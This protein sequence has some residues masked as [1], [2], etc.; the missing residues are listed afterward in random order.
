MMQVPGVGAFVRVLLPVALVGGVTLT[1]GVWLGVDPSNLQYIVREW[2]ASTYP[3][4]VLDGR[5]ASDVKPWGLLAKPGRAVVRDP[6]QT[7]YLDSSTDDQLQT[8]LEP[9][10]ASRRRDGCA[11]RG[12]EVA[13][14]HDGWE[15]MLVVAGRHRGADVDRWRYRSQTGQEKAQIL[16]HPWRYPRPCRPGANPS[17]GASSW[18]ST[19]RASSSCPMALDPMLYVPAAPVSPCQCFMPRTWRSPKTQVRTNPSRRHGCKSWSPS[20]RLLLAWSSRARLLVLGRRDVPRHAG[21]WRPQRKPSRHRRLRCGRRGV[22]RGCSPSLPAPPWASRHT[23]TRTNEPMPE[24]HEGLLDRHH[25]A[26]ADQPGLV[27]FDAAP[28]AASG[29]A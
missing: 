9:R 7:P 6:E 20:R 26:I 16:H 24:S 21:A 13:A 8:R 3:N 10:M 17:V 25:G 11:P 27:P 19:P 28:A 15:A 12:A 1:F 23:S 5:V 22:P 4:L 18:R 14:R 2:W 29:P